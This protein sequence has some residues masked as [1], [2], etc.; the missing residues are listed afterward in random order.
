MWA[1]PGAVQ[2]TPS[3][4]R[5]TQAHTCGSQRCGMNKLTRH[6]NDP[7]TGERHQD[8]LVDGH[9]ASQLQ[10]VWAQVAHGGFRAPA[11]NPQNEGQPRAGGK[12]G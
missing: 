12:G 11:P 4:K 6:V 7:H 5:S 8:I 1:T 3:G 10:P 2:V 9:L